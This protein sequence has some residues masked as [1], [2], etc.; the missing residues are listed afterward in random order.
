MHQFQILSEPKYDGWWRI[1][2]NVGKCSY[3]FLTDRW[4][5]FLNPKEW[6]TKDISTIQ[7]IQP[8]NLVRSPKKSS[9]LS[10]SGNPN[11]Y[12]IAFRNIF[13]LFVLFGNFQNFS[14]SLKM[15]ENIT[16]MIKGDSPDFYL[17][18]IFWYTRKNCPMMSSYP[19]AHAIPVV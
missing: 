7:N 3:F 13:G 17:E 1:S 2:K 8:N 14:F 12:Q 16:S 11:S 5:N 4:P 9:Y 18:S 15:A 6:K 10:K 19:N